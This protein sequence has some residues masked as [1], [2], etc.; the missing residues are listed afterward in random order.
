M[1]I[2]VAIVGLFQE[3]QTRNA[4]EVNEPQTTRPII[5]LKKVFSESC[6]Q[7]VCLV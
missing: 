4:F 6:R 3:N 5:G 7:Q 2:T 1:R